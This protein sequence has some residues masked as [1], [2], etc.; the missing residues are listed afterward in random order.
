M[1]KLVLAGERFVSLTHNIAAALL[2]LSAILVFTQVISRFLGGHSLA[3]TEVLARGTVIWMVFT[4]ASAGFR[5]NAMIPLEFIRDIVPPKVRSVVMWAVFLL[6]LVF[7]FVLSWYGTQ[8]A[9]RVANQKIAML[10]VSM[11]WFYA[12]IPI[13]CICALPG[14]II[15]HFFPVADERLPE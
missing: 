12:A 5:L 4:A 9:M 7:L 14:V 13:G 6:T 15:G 3:W 2:A 11:A 1:R 8:M 10:G